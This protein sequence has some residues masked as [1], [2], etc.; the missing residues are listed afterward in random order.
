MKKV[1]MWICLM[2]VMLMVAPGC[3]VNAAVNNGESEIQP[4]YA[5]MGTITA[6]IGISG[7]TA[8]CKGTC[9]VTKNTKSVMIVTLQRRT[10]SGAYSEY[11]SWSQTFNGTG[12]KA[13]EKNKSITSGYYYRTKVEVQIYSSN[14]SSTIVEAGAQYSSEK[15]Y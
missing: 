7:G 15:W 8:I 11:E 2:L 3:G 6:G 9:N 14:T 13:I 10:K 12:K 1:K 4:L 5:N